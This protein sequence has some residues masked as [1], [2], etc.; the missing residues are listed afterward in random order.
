MTFSQPSFPHANALAA[1]ADFLPL[2]P[3]LATSGQPTAEQF[4]Q[5]QAAGYRLVL[6]LATP[7]SATWLPEQ[8][9]LLERL[10]L[11]YRAIPVEWENPTLDD[12][13]TFADILDE[14]PDTKVWVH[15]A[16]N[17]RVSAFV[18]LYHRLRKGFSEEVSLRYLLQIWQPNETW[19]NFIDAT[20]ELYQED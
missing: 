17:M 10:G 20:L 11:G 1:I 12:F 16:K 2:S 13:E 5:I 6:N 8:A 4:E 3:T 19:K 15:C 14:N 18:Y 9:D 7:A